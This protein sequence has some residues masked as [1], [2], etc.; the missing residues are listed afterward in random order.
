MA[1]EFF[2]NA[3]QNFDQTSAYKSSWLHLLSENAKDLQHSFQIAKDCCEQWEKTGPK[4]KEWTPD[5]SLSFCEQNRTK[6]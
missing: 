5:N 4:H 1:A 2:K 3:S 6:F